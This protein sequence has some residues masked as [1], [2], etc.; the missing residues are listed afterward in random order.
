MQ[1]AF[2]VAYKIFLQYAVIL[3]YATR[4]FWLRQN[5]QK[6]A[7]RPVDARNDEMGYLKFKPCQKR[8]LNFRSSRGNPV[9][10]QAKHNAKGVVMSAFKIIK[11]NLKN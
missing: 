4:I 11:G 8:D 1:N 3:I 7:T 5:I 10:P 2:Q 9:L 6:I